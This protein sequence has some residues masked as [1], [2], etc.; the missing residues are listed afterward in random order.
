VIKKKNLKYTQEYENRKQKIYFS[1][2]QCGF[3]SVLLF[4]M[5]YFMPNYYVASKKIYGEIKK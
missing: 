1:V 5:N 4:I 3:F 2:I